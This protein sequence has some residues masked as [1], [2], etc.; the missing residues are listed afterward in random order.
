MINLLKGLGLIK[1]G[2][3]L[4][5][6]NHSIKKKSSKNRELYLL[7]FEIHMFVSLFLDENRDLLLSEEGN[8]FSAEKP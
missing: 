1:T 6:D 3:K 5:Q 4:V 8:R 2:N 7:T